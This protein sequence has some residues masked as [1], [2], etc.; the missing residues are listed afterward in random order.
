MPVPPG[1]HLGGMGLKVGINNNYPAQF[2]ASQDD[3]KLLKIA[4]LVTPALPQGSSSILMI[5]LSY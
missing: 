1:Y 5:S 3:E 4:P 2:K